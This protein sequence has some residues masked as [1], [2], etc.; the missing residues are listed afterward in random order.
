MIYCACPFTSTFSFCACSGLSGKWRHH[1][2]YAG[3]HRMQGCRWLATVRRG[4]ASNVRHVS[5]VTDSL[6]KHYYHLCP[7]FKPIHHELWEPLVN[8]DK[9]S[10]FSSIS[11]RT[12]GIGSNIAVGSTFLRHYIPL[13]FTTSTLRRHFKSYRFQCSTGLLSKN[14]QGACPQ[15]QPPML[16]FLWSLFAFSPQFVKRR[17]YR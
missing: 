12:L 8:Y 16:R 17:D 15:Q 7:L 9:G 4:A 5:L 14:V 13:K 10:T 1:H 6:T 11:G 3:Q 2:C